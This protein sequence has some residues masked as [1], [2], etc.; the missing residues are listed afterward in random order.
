MK[1]IF[2]PAIWLLAIMLLSTSF[3]LAQSW[4]AK[5]DFGGTARKDACGFSI[6]NKGY[7]GTGD[8][9]VRKKD[10]WEYDQNTDTWTQKADMPTANGRDKACGFAIGTKGYIACGHDGSAYLNDCYEYDPA[11]NSWTAKANFTGSA[12]QN[13]TGY[14]I[15]TK[16]YVT[17]GYDGTDQ[18]L[19]H[20]EFDPVANTW[21]AR[22]NFS[23]GKREKAVGFGC[24]NSR[25]YVG[26]GW[27]GSTRKRDWH[28]YNPVTNT[29]TQKGDFAGT[30]RTDACGFSIGSRGY[31]GCGNDGSLKQDFWEYDPATDIW[32][33]Q[34]DYI[35]TPRGKAVGLGIGSRGY[36]GTGEDAMGRSKTWHEFKPCDTWERK[37]DFP[38]T[39]RAGAFGF[40]INGKGYMGTGY[41]GISPEKKD[42]W[43]YNPATDIWTQ[44]ADFGG[45]ARH[46][47]Y[48]FQIGNKGYVGG[49]WDGAINNND[50]WEYD[51]SSNTWSAKAN[52]PG[53]GRIEALG[54]AINGR[55]YV[56]TGNSGVLHNDWYEYNPVLDT[57]S[58]KANFPSTARTKTAGFVIGNFGYMGTGDD[59]MNIKKDFFRYDPATD[60]WIAVADCGILPRHGAI[61][62]TLCN[63]GHIVTGR[64]DMG[65]YL[66]EHWEY[67]PL[68]NTW[69]QKIDF[70][71]SARWFSSAFVIGCSAYVGLGE[72]LG[73]AYSKELW[74]YRG[75]CCGGGGG[76]VSG[77]GG[78]GIESQ[79][80]GDIIAKRIFT[81]A[82]NN[83]SLETNYNKAPKF[84]KQNA[85]VVNGPNN[86]TLTDLIPTSVVGTTKAVVTTPTDLV[87]FTNALEVLSV[88]YL[89]VNTA[90]AVVFATRTAGNIYA[91]TKPIC[92]R[93]RGAELLEVV[94]LKVNGNNLVAYKIKQQTG[95]VEFAANLSAGVQ[96]NRSSISLQSNWFTSSYLQ[97]EKLFNFQIWATNYETVHALA[98]SIVNKL[99]T[100][101]S[102]NLM[103]NS[104]ADLPQIYVTKGKRTGSSLTLQIQNKTGFTNGHVELEEKINEGVP[105]VK[106]T[107]PLT[108]NANGLATVTIPVGDAYESSLYIYVNNKLTDLLYLSDGAW[109]ISY[110]KNLTS[111]SN[112][113][114]ANDASFINNTNEYALMRNATVTGSS[115]DYISIYKLVKAGGIEANLTAYN[116]LRFSAN[117]T[118][119][120]SIK[121]TI[122]KKSITNWNE[123]YSIRVP[124]NNNGEYEIAFADLKNNAGLA[125]FNPNDVLLANFTFE[126]GSTLNANFSANV[127]KARFIQ[128]ARQAS[129]APIAIV[130]TLT[131]FPNPNKGKFG[132]SFVAE[133]DENLVLRVIEVSSGKTIKTLF[134][135][136]KKGTNNVNIDLGVSTKVAGVYTITLES[137]ATKYQS[138]KLLLNK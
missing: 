65:N 105:A 14:S 88:D 79:S 91:H 135:N 100:V 103:Q 102:I 6:S 97:D 77:G 39:A 9:G 61:G 112:F 136:A 17:C 11:G 93:L 54:L 107:V 137:D 33:Q 92:D 84:V 96:A 108:I 36:I 19:D 75:C 51:Q 44:V 99:Q 117:A 114:V 30:Q 8:D 28:E 16:G 90:K 120:N 122:T 110:D 57:W 46:S 21:T 130:K 23:G 12:R 98:Q 129:V 47:T 133:A 89:N 118:G 60:S 3:S 5:T 37:A 132:V 71:G 138:Q 42:V 86:L 125:K 35:G 4:S 87:Q 85:T 53:A 7:V 2:T 40:A 82:I 126:R 34:P 127:S 45:T 115:K 83:K 123:Q 48:Y 49:G 20:Y 22:A 55:G 94:R 101:G 121:V 31:L 43:E 25:G 38:G 66:R 26:T 106:R 10:L 68:T 73:G 81:A 50:L 74:E 59:G 104:G 13:A 131:T 109:D 67:Q 124:L 72:Q 41:D 32:T 128:N 52:F 62:F 24:T 134:V 80:L 70:G 63:T 29:W 64:D 78:G 15:G 18:K 1:L 27:D 113:S 111:V 69:T 95:E 56:G 116:G 119:F 58:A 76:G